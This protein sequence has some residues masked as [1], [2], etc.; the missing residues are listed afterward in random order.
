M[1]DSD[2]LWISVYSRKELELICTCSTADDRVM[3]DLDRHVF[4]F[5]HFHMSSSQTQNKDTKTNPALLHMAQI[6]AESHRLVSDQ[7]KNECARVQLLTYLKRY[8]Y[9]NN[10]SFGLRG[11]FH[12]IS[13]LARQYSLGDLCA[14][15]QTSEEFVHS[16]KAPAVVS[17]LWSLFGVESH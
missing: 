10:H 4:V 17:Y 15:A 1:K 16:V 2:I 7:I 12:N 13:R 9:I 14:R 8:L 3:D 5:T 11:I 6:Q